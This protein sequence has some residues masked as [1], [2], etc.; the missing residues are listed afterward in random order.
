[1]STEILGYLCG[2]MAR[3]ATSVPSVLTLGIILATSLAAL[4]PLE[5]RF[6]PAHML[7]S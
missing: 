3:P 7:Y 5:A 2:R 4:P 1:M 6:M